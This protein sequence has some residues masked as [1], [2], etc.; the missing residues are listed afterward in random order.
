MNFETSEKLIN[1][2]RTEVQ[3]SSTN[4]LLNNQERNIKRKNRTSKIIEKVELDDNKEISK[5]K[6]SLNKSGE[7]S[8]IDNIGNNPIN[9]KTYYDSKIS[10]SN[11]F[12]FG[13]NNSLRKNMTL[14]KKPKINNVSIIRKNTREQIF[15]TEIKEKITNKKEES[16]K[17]DIS[18]LFTDFFNKQRD[19]I[20]VRNNKKEEKKAQNDDPLS[21]PKE[22][23]IFEEI[24]NYKCFKYFTKESLSKTSVPFIYINMDMNTTKKIPPKKKNIPNN[25]PYQINFNNNLKRFIEFDDVFLSKKKN[26]F[27]TEEKKKNILDN[28]YR[29]STA[30]DMYEK[31]NLIKRKKEK[32]KLKNYQYNFLKVVKHNITDKY[33]EDLKDRFNDIR[34]LAEGKYQKNYKYMKEIEKDEE[35]LIKDINKIYE[36]FMK[37]SK[38]KNIRNM[39]TKPGGS[40]IDLPQ[41]KFEKIINKDIIHSNSNKYDK[42]RKSN[43]ISLS[44]SKRRMNRTSI[45]IK[46]KSNI[47][48]SNFSSN[49]NWMMTTSKRFSKFRD[50]RDKI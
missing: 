32:K 33:Y 16:K 6:N 14:I 49:K 23:M 42:S 37:Y 1:I 24:K 46:K 31:I 11:I 36:R 28:I 40:R 29:V 34:Q 20:S 12:N 9:L 39:L 21:I 48:I 43:F 18:T 50:F 47:E 17:S 45:K 30:E 26:V 3:N 38:R 15:K 35:R 7:N 41:I 5:S 8:K 44:D 10:K 13:K 22:D 25:N 27:F 19:S 4:S 2:N